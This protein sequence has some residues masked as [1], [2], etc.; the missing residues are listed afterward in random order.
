[1]RRGW[2]VRIIDNYFS[3]IASLGIAFRVEIN[4]ADAAEYSPIPFGKPAVDP[5]L[6]NYIHSGCGKVIE[7]ER[8]EYPVLNFAVQGFGVG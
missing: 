1:M 3:E 6:G 2:I 4:L 7:I 5:A 8:P